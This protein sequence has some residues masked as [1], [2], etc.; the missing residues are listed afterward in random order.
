M[1]DIFRLSNT[2]AEPLTV[3]ADGSFLVAWNAAGDVPKMQRFNFKGQEIGNPIDLAVGG[4]GEN[5]NFTATGLS[6]GRFVVVWQEKW[7]RDVV[8]ARIFNNNGTPAGA[9]FVINSGD[10]AQTFPKVT[11]LN[12]GG[13]VVVSI[14]EGA[15]VTVTVRA[16]GTQSEPGLLHLGA[17]SATVTTLKNGDLAAFVDAGPKGD[18]SLY[19]YIYTPDGLLVAGGEVASQIAQSDAP[20]PVVT[21]LSDGTFLVFVDNLE[22]SRDTVELFRYASTGDAVGSGVY[23]KAGAGQAFSSHVVE[24]LPGGGYAVAF[25]VTD[26]M[27]SEL[28][29]GHSK[30]NSLVPIETSEVPFIIGD[31]AAPDITVLNDG[32]Y[33][34]SWFTSFVGA[35]HTDAQ[36]FDPRKNAVTWTGTDVGEQYQGTDYGDLLDGG[37]GND[38]LVGGDGADTLKGGVGA[39]RLEGG[40]EGDTYYVDN[41]GDRVVEDGWWSRDIDRV[42][43]SVSYKLGARI[44]RLSATGSDGIS[45]GGNN[46]DNTITGNSG[47]NRINGST[48]KDSLKGGAGKDTFVFSTKP[49]SSNQ[50]KI[51]DFNPVYDSIQLANEVFKKLGPG[52]AASPKKLSKSFFTIGS[53][54][55][56][57]ND[58]LIYDKNAGI[59]YY[60]ADGSGSGKAV[61]VANLSKK[62]KMTYADFYVI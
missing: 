51:L 61:A 5:L 53:K 52:S 14:N 47:A 35:T 1:S 28:H 50:D 8:H 49:S 20:A 29:V 18:Y 37:G 25:V 15:A 44:E 34:V 7:V 42:V 26:S 43:T 57:K 24:A 10:A 27:G 60:D 9:D 4:A 62:L 33:L 48:G 16:D 31:A 19:G 46:L 2:E 21:T 59:L 54:A 56:D 11:P 41:V 6:D 3:L 36:I 55:K 39:D 58:Y 40:D 17:L 13:F 22:G 38:Y 12:D 45:L 23:F 30:T 32:R